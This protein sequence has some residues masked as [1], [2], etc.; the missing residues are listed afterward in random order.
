M[1]NQV[2]SDRTS[3]I[4]FLLALMLPTCYLIYRVFISHERKQFAFASMLS[5]G[6]MMA[7]IFYTL[8][9]NYLLKHGS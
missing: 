6:I 5:K 4:Y 1:Y 7:G 9:Y 2:Q 3:F 8:I